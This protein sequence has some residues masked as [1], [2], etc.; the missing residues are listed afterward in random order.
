MNSTHG[1]PAGP[2]SA[3]NPL[4]FPAPSLYEASGETFA[5]CY[6]SQAAWPT[7]DPRLVEQP[8]VLNNAAEESRLRAAATRVHLDFE[9]FLHER[10]HFGPAAQIHA[11][12]NHDAY[13]F[14]PKQA[15]AAE[16][17]WHSRLADA[18]THRRPVEIV[19]PLFTKEGCAAK[20]LDAIGPTGA[21]RMVF[22]HF[23]QLAARVAVLHPPGLRIHVLCDTHL[24]N[25]AYGNSPVETAAYLADLRRWADA[26]PS[27]PVM[28][29]DYAEL[30]APF[31]ATFQAAYHE[32]HRRLRQDP[33]QVLPPEE[34][35]HVL[36]SM[37]ANVNTRTLGLDYPALCAAFGPNQDPTHPAWQA[38]THL[39]E[40]AT[41][42]KL[43]IKQA[44]YVTG[45]DERL[46]PHALRATVHKGLKRGRTLLGLRPYPEYYRSTRILPYHG[47]ALLEPEHG[48]WKATVHPEIALRGRTDLVRCLAP[49]QNTWFYRTRLALDG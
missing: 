2:A 41:Q 32:T 22:W 37:R 24:Y 11:L 35:R 13:Q 48:T 7:T 44:A 33:S 34:Y 14:Q 30:L 20:V 18:V 3:G 19:Y 6:L 17:L 49:D 12:L 16:P 46:F 9:R 29:H 1:S 38:V 10:R 45:A 4:G 36:K 43:A 39:A 25:S 42:E 31:R 23:E 28:V 15:F 5:R 40:R 26:L 8:T 27:H 47:V 21:E